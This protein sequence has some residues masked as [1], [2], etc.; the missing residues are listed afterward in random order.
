M[1]PDDEASSY[2][3]RREY[4]QWVAEAERQETRDRRAARTVS[5]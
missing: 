3:H 1:T 2:T 5:A 4:A